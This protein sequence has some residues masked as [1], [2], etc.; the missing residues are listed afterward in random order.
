MKTAIVAVFLASCAF[1]QDKDEP[2]VAKAKAACGPDAVKFDVKRDKAIQ[3]IGP[4]ET[5]KALVYVIEE[6][7]DPC[8]LAYCPTTKVGLDG[9]WVG[10]NQGDSYFFFTAT[11]GEH[12]LCATWQSKLSRFNQRAALSKFTAEAG[13]IYYFRTR[14]KSGAT[15]QL[16]LDPVNSDQGQFLVASFPLSIAHVKK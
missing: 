11:P 10:A 16:D 8:G 1:A 13:K 15:A 6:Q 5:D 12:H 3:P 2:A 14:V 4:A 9:S 7:L